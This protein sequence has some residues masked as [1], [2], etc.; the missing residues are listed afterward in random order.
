M[1]TNTPNP[2]VERF[3]SMAAQWREE[4]EQLRQIV[5]A[6]ELAEE[7]K[8]GKPCYT[9][10]GSNVVLIHGFKAYCALLFCQGALLKDGKG[11]LV[12]QTENVQAARQVRFTRVQEIL[13]LKPV[14]KAY[15]QEA[16]AVEKA[17]LQVIYK[18][19]A[20]LVF[21]GEF[22]TKLEANPALKK[23]F[24]A[25]TPGRQRGYHLYFTGAKQAKTREARVAKSIPLIL[26]GRGLDD[27]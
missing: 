9:W 2:E 14:L 25:L 13:K 11:I 3:F 27:V 17:G 5:L 23:A 24:A 19:P 4:Y 12:Q 16:I 1:T 8:W 22:Q 6:T 21:P 26:A 15:V 18:K 7:L 10:E 20:D